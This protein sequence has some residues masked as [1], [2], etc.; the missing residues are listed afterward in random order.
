MH[1]TLVIKRANW[2]L[3]KIL[4][5]KNISS[6]PVFVC[7][8]GALTKLASRY[9][10]CIKIDNLHINS[11]SISKR[12]E[13]SVNVFFF[14]FCHILL[15]GLGYYQ[16]VRISQIQQKA[17]FFFCSFLN[18]Y[19]CRLKRNKPNQNPKNVKLWQTSLLK[20]LCCWHCSEVLVCEKY[21]S[22]KTVKL[23]NRGW[24]LAQQTQEYLQWS[25]II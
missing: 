24:L 19:D 7:S 8:W 9:R 5:F 25:N 22:W 6:K 16:M 11:L 10:K 2:Y 23:S 3:I 18:Q 21:S 20:L 17:R 4:V 12:R 13:G 15:V 14:R 1:G